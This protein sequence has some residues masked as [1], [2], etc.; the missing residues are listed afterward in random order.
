MTTEWSADLSQEN[1]HKET[2]NLG[3]VQM[4]GFHMHPA[5]V[6]F[7]AVPEGFSTSVF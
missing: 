7:D 5:K 1:W 6:Q 3:R 2:G 4:E